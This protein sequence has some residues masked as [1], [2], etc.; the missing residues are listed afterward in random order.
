MWSGAE[1]VFRPGSVAARVALGGV[2]D[3]S[4]RRGRMQRDQ[5]GLTE[6]ALPYSDDAIGQV[7]VAGREAASLGEPQSGRCQKRKERDVGARTK[8]FARQQEPG[9]AQERGDLRIAVDVRLLAARHAAEK[10]ERRDLG[11]RG[12]NGAESRK[13]SNNRKT[14]DG[15]RRIARVRGHCPLHCEIDCHG[16]LVSDPV[17]VAGEVQ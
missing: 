10:P 8:P 6:L 7:D 3:Q 13:L 9:L 16:T 12:D 17:R 5:A 1:G 2:A 15:L 11:G 14:S 4:L